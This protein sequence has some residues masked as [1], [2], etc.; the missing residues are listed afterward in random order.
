[1]NPFK[2]R[3]APDSRGSL[4][5]M[6]PK[7]RTYQYQALLHVH[8]ND[9]APMTAGSR[10]WTTLYEDDDLVALVAR[11]ETNRTRWHAL[12]YFTRSIYGADQGLS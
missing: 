10:L 1:M 12:G 9:A 5:R 6:K 3:P 11:M 4:Q 2:K 8:A 7:P